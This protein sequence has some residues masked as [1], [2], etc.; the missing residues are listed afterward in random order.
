MRVSK[1]KRITN[2]GIISR[3]SV[4]IHNNVVSII[5]IVTIVASISRLS[6]ISNVVITYN[7]PISSSTC[8]SSI[9]SDTIIS[10][11]NITILNRSRIVASSGGQ[12]RSRIT[13]RNNSKNR[14]SGSRRTDYIDIS[15]GN[16]VCTIS[17]SG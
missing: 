5:Y 2:C 1:V 12:R 10:A 17:I 11:R 15:N 16:F 8:R 4:V 13:S 7:Y 9:N 3:I 6:I 14:R